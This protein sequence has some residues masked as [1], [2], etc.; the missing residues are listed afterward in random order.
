M[1][2]NGFDHWIETKT[3]LNESV[4]QEKGGF[5]NKLFIEIANKTYYS[6]MKLERIK[7]PVT[8]GTVDIFGNIFA[9]ERLNALSA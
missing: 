1:I 8:P 2:K 7:A 3:E 9:A 6:S 4:N 5:N